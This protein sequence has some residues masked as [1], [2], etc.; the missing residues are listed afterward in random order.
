MEEQEIIDKM[1]SIDTDFIVGRDVS[2]IDRQF[3]E[4]NKQFVIEYYR[5]KYNHW[6]DYIHSRL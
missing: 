5:D 3:F 1:E 6:R 4:V 2:E